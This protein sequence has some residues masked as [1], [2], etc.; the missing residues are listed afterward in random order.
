MENKTKTKEMELLDEA[1]QL[2]IRGGKGSEDPADPNGIINKKDC[3]IY[4]YC[5][6]ICGS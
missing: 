3:P 2:Q 6:T 1:R 4:G 5:K